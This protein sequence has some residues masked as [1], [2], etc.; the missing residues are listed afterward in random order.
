MFTLC[1]MT[2]RKYLITVPFIVLP[3]L[4]SISAAP[5]AARSTQPSAVRPANVAGETLRLVSS[6]SS[7]TGI[8]GAEI[9]AVDA[10]SKRLFITNG[11]NNTI[12]IVDI[13]N[14]KKPKLIKAVNLQSKGVTGIQSVAALNGLVVAATTVGEKTAAGR[15]FMMDVNGNLLASAPKGVEVG[16]LPDSI[17]ISP[18]GRFVLTANEGEPKD[19]CKV[20]GVLTEAS[21][22]KG[23][24]SIIDT[25]AKKLVA[26]TLDFTAFNDRANGIIYAGGR[27]YG[28]GATVAQDLEPEYIAISQDSKKAWV[29]LQENN[30][31][32]S[33][34]LETG[35]II[36]LSGLG[37]KNYNT[38]AT[39][40]DPSDRDK[41]TRVRA[42][43][44]Y[45][46]YQPDAMAVA[47]LG[48]NDYL[49]TA[50]EGDAREYPCLMGGTDSKVIEAEDVRYGSNGTNAALKTDA[51]LGR[52]NVTTFTPANIAGV[53][54]TSKSTVDDAYSLGARS[55]SVWKAPT[56]D[57]VFPAERIY[58]SGN[59][60]EKK[61]LEV[62]GGYFNADWNTSTGA[63]NLQ[64]TRSDNKGPEPEG[65]A[66]GKA[67]GKHWVVV[68]LERDGGIMLFE[69]SNPGAPQFAQ[70]ISS[71]DWAGTQFSISKPP[72]N[73]SPEGI[74]FI[75][76]KNSPSKKPLVIVSY[77]VS[78]TVAIFELSSK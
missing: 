38:D 67:Y 34:D 18:N 32:A 44:A 76:A 47:R 19:Y 12:D 16:V 1:A 77:E 61:V 66:Y 54:I 30:A 8:G 46:M 11:A 6:F 70:Y 62:N 63:A 49:F 64:D 52:L 17:H 26:K 31:I 51:T 75:E 73:I 57:G 48:G 33:V 5:S 42:V 22:P 37:F 41:E 3:I 74:L 59:F 35:S 14:I 29:T 43:P 78:G 72:G 23:S 10:K 40:I 65:I 27:I 55:F 20:G 15:V 9:S 60:I 39:G 69:V 4:A 2:K 13:S 7:G 36:G 53:N 50:N 24:I 21:D 58:D 71:T 25:T 56:I 45:G 68:G 28:P